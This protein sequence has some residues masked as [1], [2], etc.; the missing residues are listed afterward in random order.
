MTRGPLLS[1]DGARQIGSLMFI[2]V[3]DL[4]AAKAFWDG[5]PFNTGGLFER[6]EFYG[7]RFGRVFDCFKPVD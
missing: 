6:V 1:D 4:A 2:D 3:P 5:E 7:W